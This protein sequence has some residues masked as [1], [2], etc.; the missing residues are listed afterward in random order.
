MLNSSLTINRQLGLPGISTNSSE[1]ELVILW[2]SYLRHVLDKPHNAADPW[3]QAA[4]QGVFEQASRSGVPRAV[5]TDLRGGD[6]ERVLLL[7]QLVSA[8]MNTSIHR[9]RH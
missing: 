1:V 7:M 6:A 2:H 5:L 8:S 4:L 9:P 3:H